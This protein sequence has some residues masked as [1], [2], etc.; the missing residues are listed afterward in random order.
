MKYA[1]H[2]I[3]LAPTPVQEDYFRRAC[4]VARFAYNWG[5]AEWKRMYA[6]GEKPSWMAI[7]KRLNAIKD[8]LFPWMRE[9]TKLA[10]Q[11]AIQNLGIAFVKFSKWVK[12]RIGSR[13]GYPQ[14]KKKG[15]C[16]DSFCAAISE[17]RRRSRDVWCDG[18]RVFFSRIGWVRMRQPVRFNGRITRAT[19]SRTADHWYVTLLVET[20]DIRPV[21]ASRKRKAV[22]VD[23]GIKTLATTFDGKEYGE[24]E[25][26]KPLRKLLGKLRRLGRSLTRKVK[27]S[28]NRDKAK[29]KLARLY[30]RIA[31]VRTDCLHKL[32]GKLARGYRKVVVEDLNVQGMQQNRSLARSIRDMGFYE[33]RRQLAYKCDWYGTEL[34]IADRFFPSS[35]TCPDCKAVNPDVKLG[36]AFWTCPACGSWHDRDRAAAENLY[37]LAAGHAATACGAEVA[38]RKRKPPAKPAATKQEST[39]LRVG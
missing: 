24:V 7:H 30:A 23:L 34:V 38:G 39:G 17:G 8:E 14:F 20:P 36:V 18:N 5:L 27:G 29:T 35:K 16:R 19:V 22:G 25:G 6:A 31:N 9:V 28:K 12:F 33:F 32:T 13:V 11:I 21:P 37:A 2:R 1:A 26:P 3:R 10:P 4:G 15:W